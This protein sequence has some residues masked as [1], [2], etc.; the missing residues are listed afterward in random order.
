MTVNP[1]V[2]FPT[3]LIS[4]AVII[5]TVVTPAA[6]A[7]M[8]SNLRAGAVSQ[9]DWLLMTAGNLLLLFCVVVAISPLGKIRLGG[10]GATPDY[11]RLSWFA[12]LFGAGMGIGLV[13]YGVSEPVTHFT[14]SMSGGS[15]APLGGAIGDPAAARSIA[16]AATIFDWAL[17]LGPFSRLLVWRSQYSLSISTCRCR[18]DRHFIR[19]SERRYGVAPVT[20]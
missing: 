18:Y 1:A 8:F 14:S 17:L 20:R 12:M 9:F 10:K 13:F 19:C 15:G 5:F 4:L 16:M 3:A 2:F 6:S 7:D 11:S